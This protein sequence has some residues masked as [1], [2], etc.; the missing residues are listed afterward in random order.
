[1]PSLEAALLSIS[2][3]LVILFPYLLATLPLVKVRDIQQRTIFLGGCVFAALAVVAGICGVVLEVSSVVVDMLILVASIVAYKYL[4]NMSWGQTLFIVFTATASLSYVVCWASVVDAVVVGNT[5]SDKYFAWPGMTVQWGGSLVALALLWRPA[6][7][8]L[9]EMLQSSAAKGVRAFWGAAWIVPAVFFV[10]TLCTRPEY[11]ET[12]GIHNVLPVLV[13]I[14]IGVFVIIAAFYIASYKLIETANSNI[15]LVEF[16]KSA[17]LEKM[18]AEHLDERISEARRANHDM[19]QF[20]TVLET[21]V[22]NDDMEGFQTYARQLQQEL[23]ATSAI[24]YCENRVVNAIVLYYCDLVRQLGVE[25][26]AVLL[27]PED[28]PFASVE[29][30]ALFGNLLE[31]AYEALQ[32]ELENGA[33]P[34]ALVFRVRAMREGRKPFVITV[35]NSCTQAVSTTAAGAY[36]STKRTGEGIGTESISNIAKRHNGQAQFDCADGLFRASIILSTPTE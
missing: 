17:S 16:Q 19:R 18:Y 11:P 33:D 31:N 13:T 9:P 36:L 7:D 25:P 20:L 32:R 28:L 29:L 4:S 21:C 8:K 26:D 34:T 23:P 27:V 15:A 30:T 10:L 22:A 5:L 14:L 24:R 2:E 6:A 35:D 1:M 12:L 3:Q